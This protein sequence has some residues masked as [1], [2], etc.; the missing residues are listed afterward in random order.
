[1]SASKRVGFVG[2]RSDLIDRLA[3][4]KVL[5]SIISSE[6]TERLIYQMLVDGHFRK[7]LARLRAPRR[8]AT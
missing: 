5:T 6:L 7:H 3:D 1:M 4:I 8:G 2:S